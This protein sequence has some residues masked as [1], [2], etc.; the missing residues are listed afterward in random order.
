[1]EIAEQIITFIPHSL[2]TMNNVKYN[3]QQ[4]KGWSQVKMKAVLHNQ[5]IQNV[6][7]K[8]DQNNEPLDYIVIDQFAVRGVYQNYALSRFLTLTKRTLKPRANLNLLL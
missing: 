8:I 4:R 2:L 3:E 5:A 1:M 7:N 6:V